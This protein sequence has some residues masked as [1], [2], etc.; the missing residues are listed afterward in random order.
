MS[1]AW[2]PFVKRRRT[3]DRT[4]VTFELGKAASRFWEWVAKTE[5]KSGEGQR[6]NVR[7]ARHKARRS[8]KANDKLHATLQDIAQHTGKTLEEVKLLVKFRAVINRGYSL[9]EEWGVPWPKPSH[10]ADSEDASK[11]IEEAMDVAVQFEVP[12]YDR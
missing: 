1:D 5:E 11:L 8:L 9:T 10:L 2:L 7:I 12:G 3:G 4:V 6:Y